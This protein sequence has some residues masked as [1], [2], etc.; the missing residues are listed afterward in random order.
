MLSGFAKNYRQLLIGV[1]VGGLGTLIASM[2]S[3]I[4]YKAYVKEYH[5]GGGEFIKIFTLFNVVFL[6][7]LVGVNAYFYG[8]L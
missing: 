8:G 2:A 7:A 1:N 3:L 5:Q 4:S 6:I